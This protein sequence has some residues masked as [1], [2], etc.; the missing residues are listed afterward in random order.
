MVC[1]TRAIIPLYLCGFYQGNLE[2]SLRSQ[3][4]QVHHLICARHWELLKHVISRQV[5]LHTPDWRRY[6]PRTLQAPM[7]DWLGDRS[8]KKSWAFT[9]KQLAA[10]AILN[11]PNM[12][13]F[14]IFPTE[15]F[16]VLEAQ[17]SKASGA[18]IEGSAWGWLKWCLLIK[19]MKDFGHTNET[20]K[21]CWE[22]DDEKGKVSRV[23][24]FLM[25]KSSNTNRIN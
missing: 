22:R 20:V 11:P 1:K 12:I 24:S 6:W 7:C 14:I 10:S 15:T 18:R 23:S 17:V 25:D 19:E 5:G 2:V 8:Q 4:N 21:Q 3:P 9:H 13:S 16:H